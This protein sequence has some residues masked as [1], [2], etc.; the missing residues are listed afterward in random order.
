MSFPIVGY[1]DCPDCGEPTPV[2]TEYIPV[3]VRCPAGHFWI[4]KF[5]PPEEPPHLFPELEPNDP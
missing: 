5:Y 3:M 2:Y 4:A 1:I